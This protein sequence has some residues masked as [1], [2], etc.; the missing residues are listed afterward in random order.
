MNALVE[1]YWARA[2]KIARQHETG[3]IDFADLTG[4]S[5]EYSA[6][7]TEQLNELPEA[8]RT[9]QGTALEAKL[10]QAIGDDNTSE[11]TRQ[12]LNEL[13]ISINRTPIY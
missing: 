8:L 4:L 2:L 1:Q 5:D 11:H 13:L 7:F 9:A 10:Q 12:A 6:S 3:E